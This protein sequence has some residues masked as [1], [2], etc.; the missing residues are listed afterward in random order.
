MGSR[1]RHF[2]L[3][4]VLIAWVVLVTVAGFELWEGGGQAPLTGFPGHFG[5]DSGWLCLAFHLT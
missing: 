4:V 3:T 2:P 1:W 5:I